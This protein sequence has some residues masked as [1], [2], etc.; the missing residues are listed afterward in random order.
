MLEGMTPPEKERL[1]PMVAAAMETFD[2]K[3]LKIFVDAL[4]N[5]ALWSTS[6][7]SAALTS[8]GFKVSHNQIGKHRRKECSCAG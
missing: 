4:N 6:Q 7:L 3:D 1:C 8:R 5:A 2:D